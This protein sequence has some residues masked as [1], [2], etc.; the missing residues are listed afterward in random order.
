MIWLK[1]S[2]YFRS[3]F[4]EHKNKKLFGIIAAVGINDEQ[5]RRAEKLGIYVVKISDEIFKLIS[6]KDFKPKDFS[7]AEK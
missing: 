3:F 2:N 4:P 6:K 5:K 7:E 1:L